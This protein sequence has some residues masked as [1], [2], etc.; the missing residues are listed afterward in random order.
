MTSIYLYTTLG[1]TTSESKTNYKGIFIKSATWDSIPDEVVNTLISTIDLKNVKV[2]KRL[3]LYPPSGR[4]EIYLY[5]SNKTIGVT[6]LVGLSAYEANFSFEE[7]QRLKDAVIGSWFSEET[8]KGIIL[9]LSFKKK[10]GIEVGDKVRLYGIELTVYGF[11]NPQIM[12][13][14][15]RDPDNMPLVPVD[16][17]TVAQQTIMEQRELTYFSW[18]SVAIVPSPLLE[19]FHES[20]CV[21]VYLIIN[22]NSKIIEKLSDFAKAYSDYVILV[23]DGKKI[24]DYRNVLAIKSVGAELVIVPTLIAILVIF[25][26]IL[27]NIMERVKE[28]SIYS[29]LGLTPSHIA[30]LF[31]AEALTYAIIGGVLGYTMGIV[32]L[33][34]LSKLAVFPPGFIPNYSSGF[35]INTILFTMGSIIIASLYPLY[36]ASKLVTPS[37]ERKWRLRAVKER[38]Q[39]IVA[40]PF[41]ANGE[42]VPVVLYYIAEFFESHKGERIEVF[43]TRELNFTA[44]REPLKC[45]LNAVVSVEPYEAGV[46]QHVKII[47][48]DIGGNRYTFHLI[49]K[50]LS[51]IISAWQASLY[52]FVNEVR[53]QFLLWRTLTPQ[54]REQYYKRVLDLWR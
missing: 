49:I 48:T 40:L 17:E 1:Y 6:A 32:F 39:I 15:A 42:E 20:H 27:S 34:S 16:P 45:D 7:N 23:A 5:Y 28:M 52:K 18:D 26:T 38:D 14:I 53:K 19:K 54:D 47:V 2:S 31:L 24:V 10:Y 33:S 25:N 21:S 37:L 46:T 11:F 50:R 29:A 43:S 35:V 9:P 41:V 44:S 30:G 22:P 12:L 51:G 8:M 3:W 13:K 36:K 4:E